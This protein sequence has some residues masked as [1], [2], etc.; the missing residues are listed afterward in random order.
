M[1]PL[2]FFEKLVQF[3]EFGSFSKSKFL[4]QKAF[5]STEKTQK[6]ENDS[7]NRLVDKNMHTYE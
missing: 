2:K 5:F 3:G 6:F 1:L 4:V 7:S